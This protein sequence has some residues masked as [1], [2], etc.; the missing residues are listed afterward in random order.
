M[1][2]RELKLG[3]RTEQRLGSSEW[4][5][6]ELVAQAGGEGLGGKCGFPKLWAVLTGTRESANQSI[7]RSWPVAWAARRAPGSHR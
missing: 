2:S 1:G 5:D 4:M 7:G 3:S 6:A